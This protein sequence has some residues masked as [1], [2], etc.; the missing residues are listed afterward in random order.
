[1]ELFPSLRELQID[2]VKVARGYRAGWDD[3]SE[4]LANLFHTAHAGSTMMKAARGGGGLQKLVLTR[5]PDNDLTRHVVR[6]MAK[7]LCPEGKIGVAMKNRF[8]VDD[9]SVKD[10]VSQ[11]FE[12]QEEPVLTWM[13]I[14]DIP[15]L[16]KTK[17]PK[18][19]SI[20]HLGG[21]GGF[22]GLGLR[23]YKRIGRRA[24]RAEDHES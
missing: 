17:H 13:G 18:S 8:K 20:W 16:D 9:R 3:G 23:F 24:G 6:M 7:L 21:E 15:L 10:E 5:L 14:E 4:G 1:M 19:G 22:A 12:Q 2:F 11:E